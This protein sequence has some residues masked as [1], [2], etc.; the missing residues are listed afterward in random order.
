MRGVQVMST[1]RL[2]V[3]VAF[4]VMASLLMAVAVITSQFVARALAE[5][6]AV[7]IEL[8]S[9]PVVVAKTLAE[10]K[11][12]NFDPLAYQQRLIAE[13]NQFLSQLSAKGISFTQVAV[14]APNGP[15][16]EIANIQF[17]YNYVFN[18]LT[19]AVPSSAI[20]TI[21][22][23]SAVKSVHNDEPITMNL[24][25]AVKYVRAPSLYGN[26]PQVHQGD[27]LNTGGIE[28]QGIYIAILDTGIDWTHPMFGGDPTPPR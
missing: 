28:G 20:E 10:A 3:R 24:D 4:I 1:N 7:I 18:G 11:N 9:D 23:M 15:N 19:L 16:G 25:N 22:G 27:S 6:Q 13:Q 12:Q 2:K 8:K 17:R 14:N 21:R 5:P 26:P